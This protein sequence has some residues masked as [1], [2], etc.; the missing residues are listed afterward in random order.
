MFEKAKTIIAE[1]IKEGIKRIDINKPLCLTT[2][3]SRLG[4]GFLLNQKTCAC[5]EATRGKNTPNCCKDGWKIIL[6]G[7]KYNSPAESRYAPIEGEL[8]GIASALHKCRYFF[9][10]SILKYVFP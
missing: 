4:T 9:N 3:W 2:D 7:G 8:L 10:H 1:Q 5:K 6:A